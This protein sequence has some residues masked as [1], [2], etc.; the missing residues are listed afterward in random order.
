LDPSTSLWESCPSCGKLNYKDSLQET[1][2]ICIQC[3]YYF[4]KPPKAIIKTFFPDGGTFINPP[5]NLN[6]DPLNFKME[7]GSYRDKLAKTRK[8][9]NQWCSI[10]AYKGTIENLKVHLI[11]SNFKF[12]GGSWSNNEAHYFR[13]AVS[14]AIQ[15]S[16]DVFVLVLKTGG[17]SMFTSTIGLNSV[18]TGGIIGMNELKANNILT[19]SVGQSKTTGGVLASVHYASEIVIYEKNAHD[20]TFAGKKISKNY[21]VPGESMDEK[22]GTAEEKMSKGMCDLV[23]NRSEIK[24]TICT[25]AKIIKKKEDLAV[26]DEKD[27]SSNTSREVL[28]KTAEKI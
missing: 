20:I 24:S 5:K 28:P 26:T 17:V 3:S 27:D 25:L 14:D 13:K 23:L 10:L 7:T 22:F 9:E 6:D 18:M 4:D 12:L 15:D 21:L 8:K 11:V 2:W 1:D 16:C 19:V